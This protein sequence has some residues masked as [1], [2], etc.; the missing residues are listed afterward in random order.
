MVCVVCHTPRAGQLCTSCASTVR[1]GGERL[2]P[3]GLRVVAAFEHSGAAV[4]LIHNLKYRGLASVATLVGQILSTQI[5]PAPL[6]PVPRAWS[7]RL[8]HGVDPGVEIARA[9]ADVWGEPVL[10][11]LATPVHYRRR[12]GNSHRTPV[13]P[14]RRRGNVPMPVYVVDDVVTTGSTVIEAA[15][16]IGPSRVLGVLAASVVPEVSSLFRPVTSPEPGI[17]D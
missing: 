17:G 16:G 9:I 2:L 10:K 8:K 12:A 3:G 7:R 15:R 6:V 4:P 11:V 14:F 13:A 5:H 1:P